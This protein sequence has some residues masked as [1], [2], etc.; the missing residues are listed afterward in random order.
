VGRRG[1]Y[2]PNERACEQSGVLNNPMRGSQHDK[3]RGSHH[4]RDGLDET[5]LL[6]SHEQEVPQNA[7]TRTDQSSDSFDL[8]ITSL[9]RGQ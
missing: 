6:L 4:R 9:I 8:S 3:G 2:R 5:R 1:Q 7:H